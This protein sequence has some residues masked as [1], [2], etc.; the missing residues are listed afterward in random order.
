MERF[1]DALDA[2]IDARSYYAASDSEWRT[3]PTAERD[4]LEAALAQLLQEGKA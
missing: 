2:Y 3:S 1:L 4:E